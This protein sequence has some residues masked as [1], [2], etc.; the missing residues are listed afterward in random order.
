MKVLFV[1]QYFWPEDFRINDVVRSL[2]E[3]GHEVDVLTGNPNYPEGVIFPGYQA[4]G[5]RR[6]QWNGATIYRIPIIGRGV[7]SAV[8]LA[9]NYLSFVISGLVLAPWSLRRRSYDVVF[10]YCPSPILQAIPA[11]FLGWLKQAPVAIWVQ[12]LWPESLS[13]TGYVSSPVILRLVKLIVRLIY[14]KADL[15]LVQSRA[16]EA[17][18]SA[19]VPGKSIIYYPNSVNA[20]FCSP[21]SE[22][23]L[24]DIPQLEE[25]FSVMFAGNIGVGQAVEVIVAAADLLRGYPE[26]R[27]VVFG[28]GSRWE[29]LR[30][31]VKARGLDNVHLLGRFPAET[32]PG[33]MQRSS[34]LLVTLADEPIFAATVPN[35]VQ[36]YMAAGRPILACLNGEGARLVAE[37]Q[38]GLTIPAEDSVALA[39]AT[40]QLFQMSTADR[41]AFGSN[42]RRYFQ[43][44]FD[45]E[46]LTDELVGIFKRLTAQNR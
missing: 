9:L 10:V 28:T 38:A 20:L 39:A 27:F 40:L 26:I 18:I 14:K 35:K 37:A 19:M 21:N 34:A 12:D 32:M 31:E 45:H 46:H 2:V 5:Y 24:P 30:D 11:L 15:L 41:E 29:W 13:A 3:R 36:A 42:G 4:F 8:K 33:F 23:K 44:H 22:V 7:K 43:R 17:H 1:T 16:F 6:E 25:G